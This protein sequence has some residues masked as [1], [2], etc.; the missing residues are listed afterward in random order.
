V[1]KGVPLIFEVGPRDL[2]SRAMMWLRRDHL[3]VTDED[4]QKVFG[5]E[6]PLTLGKP[7]FTRSYVESLPD[8]GLV[9]EDIQRSLHAQ[10][11]ARRD[12]KIVRGIDT[13]D[14]LRAYYGADAKHPGWI[15]TQWCRPTGG[16]LESV[17]ELLKSMKLTLRN[18]PMDPS[19]TN[20]V[21]LF[22]GK[23]AVERIYVARSY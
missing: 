17:I 10:A 11:T 21:C 1:K 15:E 8:F 16:E 14:A 20:G 23:P 22:T 12:D 6:R 13:L 7:L 18:V 19:P 5:D 4:L 2:A 9:L 3:Y